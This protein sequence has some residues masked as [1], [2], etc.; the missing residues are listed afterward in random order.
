MSRRQTQREQ[1]ARRELGHT[2]VSPAT[3]RVLGGVFLALLF[4]GSLAQLGLGDLSAPARTLVAGI[5]DACGL[6]AF[7]R[8]FDLAAGLAARLRP[9]VQ[10]GLVR[11]GAGNESAY[12]GRDGWLFH[13]VSVDAALGGAFLDPRVQ[14]RRVRAAGA[15]DP[16]PQPDP[17]G[18]VTEWHA[19]LAR[20]G[21]R[22]V[23]LPVPAKAEIHPEH[24]VGPHASGTAV[25]NASHDRFVGALRSRGVPV[26]DPYDTLREA[27]RR[28]GAAAYLASDTHWHPRAMEAVAEALAERIRGELPL[29]ALG[30]PFERGRRQVRRR[31][32]IAALLDLDGPLETLEIRPVSVPAGPRRPAPVIV[33]GDSYTNIYASPAAF[34]GPESADGS[35][36]GADAGLAEQLAFHLKAPVER[37]ALND[38]GAFA[39]RLELARRVRAARRTGRDPL[40]GVSVVVWQFASRELAFGDWRRIDLDAADT[41]DAA[42]ERSLPGVRRVRA[43]IVDRA[44]L[45]APGGPYPDALVA[46]RIGEIESLDG[47]PHPEREGVVYLLA[48]RENRALP[49]VSALRPGDRVELRLWDFG[50]PAVAERYA[51][52][53]RTELDDPDALLLPAWFGE[54]P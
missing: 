45:P 52:L 38:D 24:L 2:Q 7:E 44:P 23:V 42:A 20:R 50:E 4:G 16:L 12:V 31:G 21:V 22:L 39:S 5:P 11:L 9:A 3:A 51:A 36:W 27:A 46:L 53:R 19:A 33:L 40:D 32:D 41:S 29:G 47:R 18:A 10:S 28:S 26:F 6:R 48:L 15:C 37:I 25:R 49:A 54:L 1:E 35:G 13:R 30:V 8:D 43:S 14:A 17:L 34:A